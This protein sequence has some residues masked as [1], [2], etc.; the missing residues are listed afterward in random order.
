MMMD[1]TLNTQRSS[2]NDQI[3]QLFG[4]RR[5]EYRAQLIF[6]VYK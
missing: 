3:Q 4:D 1:K 5:Y 6:Y 2:F